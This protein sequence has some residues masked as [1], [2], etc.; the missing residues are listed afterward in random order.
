MNTTATTLSFTTQ[1]VA[2]LLASKRRLSS[3]THYVIILLYQKE[4]MMFVCT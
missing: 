2:P 1:L 4:E 3:Y